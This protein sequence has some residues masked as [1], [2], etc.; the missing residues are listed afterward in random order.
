MS[1]VLRLIQP[2]GEF[3]SIIVLRAVVLSGIVVGIPAFAVYSVIVIPLQARIQTGTF[4]SRLGKSPWD[5]DKWPNPLKEPDAFPWYARNAI[6]T[7]V[8]DLSVKC[9]LSQPL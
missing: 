6:I 5:A 7:I 2:R 3:I 9:I 1:S 4:T 8:R